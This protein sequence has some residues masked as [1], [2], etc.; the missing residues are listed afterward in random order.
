[1][2]LTRTKPLAK[3]RKPRRTTSPRC[4]TRGCKKPAKV[5]GYCITH[6]D[7]ESWRLFSLWIRNRD[8]GCTAAGLFGF[9]CS[10]PLQAAHIIGRRNWKVRLDPRNVHALCAAHHR[11]VDSSGRESFKREWAMRVFHYTTASY[12]A[13]YRDALEF[14][15]RTTAIA[16]ALAWLEGDTE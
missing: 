1:M 15:D 9:P 16:A 7:R 6:G 8:G 10:G 11:H 5:A 13:L 4:T 2:S 3:K 14:G 12:E